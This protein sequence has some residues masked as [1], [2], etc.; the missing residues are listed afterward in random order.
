GTV[1]FSLL[2][3]AA[4]YTMSLKVVLHIAFA[5]ANVAFWCGLVLLIFKLRRPVMEAVKVAITGQMV[6]K[7]ELNDSDKRQLAV[8]IFLLTALCFSVLVLHRDRYGASIYAFVLLGAGI[9]LSRLSTNSRALRATVWCGLVVF[10]VAF[11]DHGV[12]WWQTTFV[13]RS[14]V[15]AKLRRAL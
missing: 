9:A 13:E 7:S 8:L 10:L 15:E 14:Q 6:A 12:D 5:L 1:D 4:D 11:V 3:S 2:G